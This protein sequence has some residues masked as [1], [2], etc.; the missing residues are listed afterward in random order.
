MT[1]DAPKHNSIKTG[2]SFGITSGVITT[3][4]LMVGLSQGTGSKLA[5]IGGV[6]TIA[7]ADAL[8]DALGIHI[9]EEAEN[10]HTQREIWLSTGATFLTKLI[11]AGSFIIPILLFDLNLA[12]MISVLWGTFLLSIFSYCLAR[13]NGE[14]P[15]RVIS[16]HI[17]VAVVVVIATY[18]IGNFI[19]IN[20]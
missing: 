15:Y 8:S 10:N 20:F 11:F 12:M 9:S 4:G 7:V 16:E 6:L 18:L 13:Q 1:K 17:I 14:K 19:K 3:L 2:F 5:V